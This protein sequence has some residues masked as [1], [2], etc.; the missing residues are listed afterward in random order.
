MY[1]LSQ[2][3]SG[4]FHTQT[5]YNDELSKILFLIKDFDL[6]QNHLMMKRNRNY[7]RIKVLFLR[8][9]RTLKRL[10]N[11]ASVVAHSRK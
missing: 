5:L 4:H 7:T 11:N 1:R 9:L 6:S 3:L 2:H 10:I 8:T